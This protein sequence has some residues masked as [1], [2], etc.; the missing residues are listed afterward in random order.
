MIEQQNLKTPSWQRVVAELT[1]PVADDRLFLLRLVS[2]LGQVSGARQ[3]VLHLLGGQRDDSPAGPE[4]RAALVWPL[5]PDMVDA[6]GRMTLPVEQLLDPARVAES[7]IERAAEAKNAA[8]AVATSRQSV[9]YALD[10]DDQMYDPSGGR[11]HVIAVPIT[12]GLPSEAA[13]LPLAGVVTLLLDGRSRQALQTTLALVEVLAGYVFSHASQQAL[14]RVQASSRS[15]DLAARL[16]ASV[17]QTPNFK[18]CCFQFVNDLCRA[19][20]VDRVALGW[21]HG[22][23]SNVAVRRGAGGGRQNVKVTALSDTENLDRRMAMIQKL[24]AAMEECLDQEQTVIYPPPPPSG[25]EADAVLSGAITHAHRELAAS[26]AKLRVASFPLRVGDASGDRI[27]GIV[28]VEST[29]DTKIDA[30]A[31]ELVQSALDLVAPVLAVRHSD[32]RLIALRVWD[33][34]LKTAAWAVGPKHT[35]WKAAGVAVMVATLFMFFFRTT[36][37]FGA[38][39]ELQPRERRTISAPF[40]GTIA[41]LGKGVEPGRKVEAG[42]TLLEFDTTE[43]R[44]SSLEARSQIVQFE[45]EADEQLKKGNLSEA[46]QAKAKADQARAK[47]QLLEHEISRANVG[48]PIG[49]VIIAGDLKDKVGAAVKLGEKL[50]ELADLSDMVVI[51]KVDDRDISM[52]SLGQTGEISPKSDPS[53]AIPFTVERIVPL[54]QA[55]EG[56]NNFEVH[57]KLDRTPG[58]FRPGMEGHAKFDGP[59]KNL[60][61]IASRRILDTL[62]VWLWW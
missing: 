27:V 45:T 16:L 33:W 50:F 9:V 55:A 36:Y 48:A 14:R 51:A 24:E 35:V 2:V 20:G 58:W 60:A 41:T 42:Q 1:V 34:V 52:I 17:N 43:R 21:V 31:A 59:R 6:S 46:Q 10:G 8:R 23:G 11:G 53:L 28:L 15:M 47:M 26:D 61:W 12:S 13:S 29:G 19:L 40:D 5:A 49:G 38:A 3:A 57:C 39:M 22:S 7:S 32:D 62:R 25:P 30:S 4:P 44:L 37:R 56:Q 18:G 54:A